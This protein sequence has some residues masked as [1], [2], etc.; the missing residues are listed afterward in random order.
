MTTTNLY[1]KFYREYLLTE[2]VKVVPVPIKPINYPD[3]DQDVDYWTAINSTND[4]IDW[5]IMELID[6]YYQEQ[7]QTFIRR[8]FQEWFRRSDLKA[9]LMANVWHPRNFEKFRY[10]DPDT[11]CEEI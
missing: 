3:V 4:N 6:I 5:N 7:Q 2:R 8:K 9:E 10:L 1:N 11:F